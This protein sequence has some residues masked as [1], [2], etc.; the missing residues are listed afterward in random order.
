MFSSKHLF[1]TGYTVSPF[2]KFGGR[3]FAY[4]YNRYKL[5]YA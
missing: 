1:Q 3:S 2:Q 4:M 5:R